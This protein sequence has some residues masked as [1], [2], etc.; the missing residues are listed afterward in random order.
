MKRLKHW[1]YILEKEDYKMFM[2]KEPIRKNKL[3]R[4]KYI[5]KELNSEFIKD[6]DGKADWYTKARIVLLA[7][8]L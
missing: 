6:V 4:K 5:K 8:S 3:E 7:N 2:I 1:Q